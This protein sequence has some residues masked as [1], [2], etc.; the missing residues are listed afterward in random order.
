MSTEMPPMGA[1]VYQGVI[2]KADEQPFDNEVVF[3]DSAEGIQVCVPSEMIADVGGIETI[4][5]TIKTA[6]QQL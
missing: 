1:V 3:E 4:E 6:E 5:V 2:E